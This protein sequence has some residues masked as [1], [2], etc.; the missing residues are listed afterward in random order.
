MLERALHAA[1]DHSDLLRPLAVSLHMQD[2]FTEAAALFGRLAVKHPTDPSVQNNLG[3]ALG[4]AGDADAAITAL[5]YACELA[6]DRPN[7]WY[8]LAKALEGRGET[9][10]AADALGRVLALEPDDT[11]SLLQRADLYKAMG[12]I[13]EAEVDL[14]RVSDR[15]PHSIPAWARLANLKAVQFSSDDL[16]AMESAYTRASADDPNRVSL[17]FAYGQALESKGRFEQAF[18]VLTEANAAKS[19]EIPWDPHATEQRVLAMRGAFSKPI[20][21]ASEPSQGS[22]AI[23]MFGMPRSGSTLLEQM[24]ASHPAIEGGGEIGDLSIVIQE[25]SKRRGMALEAWAGQAS[26]DDWTRLGKAYLSRTATWRIGKPMF[27]DKELGKGPL[28]GAAHAMLPGAHFIHCRRDPVET[29]WSCFK[30][31]F[32]RDLGFTYDLSH[33]ATYWSTSEDMLDF[34]RGAHPGLIYDYAYERLLAGPE[35]ELERILTFCGLRFDDACMRFYDSGRHVRTA[36]AGQVRRP[37]TADSKVTDRYGTL[38]DPLRRA[39]TR[40]A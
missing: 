29:C 19:R 14:R 10:L 18:A 21:Q 37:L 34:W 11:K 4:A 23:L 39:L 40:G 30:L 6:P 38:L 28:I 3:S 8:N 26:P 12:R 25:E 31:E 16:A 5:K 15:E 13:A 27:T 24:L 17:G 32:E 9:S 35:Q 33:L 7:Y 36:S 20:A 1:P 22:E 2:R